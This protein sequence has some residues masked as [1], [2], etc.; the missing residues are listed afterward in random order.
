MSEIVSQ[1]N[2]NAVVLNSD[3]VIG[4]TPILIV[5][6]TAATSVTSV[7]GSETAVLLP[8]V[9][10]SE[11][12]SETTNLL[13]VSKL[14]RLGKDGTSSSSLSADLMSVIENSISASVS[15]NL[16]ADSPDLMRTLTE[17]EERVIQEL[18]QV[19]NYTCRIYSEM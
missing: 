5:P 18:V 19:R 2:N 9:S 10:A 12:N 14:A 17:S 3:A 4:S 7:P 6:E 15:T 13:S 11:L 16:I 1:P 8:V